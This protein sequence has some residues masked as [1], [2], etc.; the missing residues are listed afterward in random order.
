M[1]Y[2]LITPTDEQQDILQETAHCLAPHINQILH[3]WSKAYR[4]IDRT[5]DKSTLYEMEQIYRTYFKMLPGES[6]RE[7]LHDRIAMAAKRF[8]QRQVTFDHLTL[9]FHLFEDSC[10][11]YI[12]KIHPDKERLLKAIIALDYMC[13]ACLS[14]IASSYFQEKYDKK[15]RSKH[16]EKMSKSLAQAYQL[17]PREIEILKRIVDGYKNREIAEMFRISVK[18]VEHHRAS[19]MQKLKAHSMV[20]LIKFAIRHKMA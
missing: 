18:T 9:S 13:H 8:S 6:N 10:L 15:T 16:R 12:R 11:P 19:L 7:V 14:T 3:H 17:T 2:Q 5:I 20:D 1:V 4:E